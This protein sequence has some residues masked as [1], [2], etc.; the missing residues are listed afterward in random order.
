MC[1]AVDPAFNE[2]RLRVAGLTEFAVIYR[3]P[4]EWSDTTAAHLA[5]EQSKQVQ[6]LV[7]EKLIPNR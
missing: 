3:Y 1:A 4:G 2:L 7:C 6:A 5:L